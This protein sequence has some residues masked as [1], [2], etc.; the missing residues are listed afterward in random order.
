MSYI[1]PVRN[2][3]NGTST[4][5]QG[6]LEISATPVHEIG[7]RLA[8]RDGRVFRYARNGAVALAPGTV[9]QMD[10]GVYNSDAAQIANSSLITLAVDTVAAGATQATVTISGLSAIDAN[11]YSGALLMNDTTG[12]CYRIL[13]HPAVA[14][15]GT[16]IVLTL[17]DTVLVTFG[18]SDTA[19]II[20]NPYAATCIQVASASAQTG[21]PVGVSPM[22]VTAQ[23]YYW[24]QTWGTCCTLIEGTSASL[25]IGAG[26]GIG[27]VAGSVESIVG[28]DL[29]NRDYFAQV[30]WGMNTQIDGKYKPVWLTI[31]P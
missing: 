21:A 7:E 2:V 29:S 17:D 22:V 13:S 23:Y 11:M 10:V 19:S 25:E 27:T 4:P 14:A 20:P 1:N 18:A 24:V 6:I 16:S 26:V 12:Y 3:G 9:V 8:L 31:A 28:T 30:G 5:G 15:S